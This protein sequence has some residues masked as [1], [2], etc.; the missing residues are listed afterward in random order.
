MILGVDGRVLAVI[1]VVLVIGS[2]VQ[3]LVGLG[4]NLV[5]APVV[6]ILDPSLMPEVPLLLATVL[7]LMT[8]V[9]SHAEIDW[10]GLGWVLSARLPGTAA[11]VWM[12]AVFSDRHLGITVAVMVLLAVALTVHSVE[13]PVRPA[14]LTVAGFLSGVAGTAT[15]IG[16]PPVAL[17][18][19]HRS[20]DQIRS[21]LAIL[22]TVGAGMSLAGIWVAGHFEIRLLV[23]ALLLVPCLAVGTWVGGRLHGVVP[24][25][26]IRYAVLVVCGASAVA[27]LVRSL[28][29]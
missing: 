3:G 25:P 1:A 2:A 27:L 11:G 29:G 15:S 8:L 18:Y 9:R 28:L 7:P 12:L 16:G 4:L 22:F 23:L 26:V 13:V 14:T 21:T 17:L 19:Q 24:D 5:S 10:G 6:T 20:P